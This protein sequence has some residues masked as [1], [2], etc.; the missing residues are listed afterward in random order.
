MVVAMIQMP[1]RK[2]ISTLCHSRWKIWKPSAVW[3]WFSCLCPWE[4]R[5]WFKRILLLVDISKREQPEFSIME[6]Y[7]YDKVLWAII[8]Y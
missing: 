3:L 2:G 7:T 1:T 5:N 8:F 6:I 4:E